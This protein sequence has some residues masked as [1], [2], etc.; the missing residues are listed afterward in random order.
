MSS[1]GSSIGVTAARAIDTILGGADQPTE[2]ERATS[3]EVLERIYAVTLADCKWPEDLDVGDPFGE[4]TPEQ[5]E[6]ASRTYSAAADYTARLFYQWMLAVPSAADDMD[7]LYE[8]IRMTRSEEESEM[9]SGLTGFQVGF[10]YNV[11]RNL[12]ELPETG[13]PAIITIG[14][15]N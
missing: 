3:A 1:D 2:E 5:A 8:A 12:C 11:A 6:A 10:A 9:M 4:R 14:K 15:D 13:N 7:R